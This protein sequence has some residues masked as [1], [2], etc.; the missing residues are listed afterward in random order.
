[1]GYYEGQRDRPCPRCGG[2]VATVFISVGPMSFSQKCRGCGTTEFT[3]D[4]EARLGD[5]VLPTV[6]QGLPSVP[7]DGSE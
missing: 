4:E 7:T 5:N 1:M 6:V 3:Q 2:I